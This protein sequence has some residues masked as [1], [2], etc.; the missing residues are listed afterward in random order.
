MGHYYKEDTPNRNER[1]RKK[2]NGSTEPPPLPYKSGC[3]AEMPPLDRFSFQFTPKSVRTKL[4]PI[5]YRRRGR[6]CSEF[7]YVTSSL[8]HILLSMHV[9]SKY[10][11]N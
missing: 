2:I 6:R 4:D 1:K 9:L 3:G 11:H 7:N 10:A 5:E 8:S